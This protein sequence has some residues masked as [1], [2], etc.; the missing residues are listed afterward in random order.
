MLID[1][2][3]VG[4]QIVNF[5]ILVWL[6]K[7]FLY[8][9]VLDALD[10]REKRIAER[11]EQAERTREQAE[12]ERQS[13]EERNAALEDEREQRLEK[14]RHEA[15]AERHRLLEEAREAAKTLRRE[16][17]RRLRDE[18]RRLSDEI[19]RRARDEIIALVRRALA[20]LADVD[21]E[22]AMARAFI[23]RLRNLEASDRETLVAAVARSDE[24]IRIR[25]A[26]PLP[27]P[28]REAIAEAVGELVG[29][30]LPL[31]FEVADELLAGIEL[32]APG[33]KLAWSL[34]DYLS[35]FER[36]LGELPVDSEEADDTG[37]RG[38]ATA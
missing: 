11:I 18:T 9:P 21:V 32:L 29:A 17:E 3:T 13:Y 19:I 1:W 37:S 35:E 2:F 16:R 14:A 5:A 23:D 20:D 22:R 10:A 4:A 12:R 30:R 36:R 26:F 34:E 8:R 7:R 33:E 24:P 38:G 15:E 6:L 27:N 31:K 25:S 28:L